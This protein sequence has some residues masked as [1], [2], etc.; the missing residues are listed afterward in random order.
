[1]LWLPLL[2]VY[3]FGIVDWWWSF[4]PLLIAFSFL[5]LCILLRSV[6]T[7]A[8]LVTIVRITGLVVVACSASADLPLAAWF[9]I[10]ALTLLDLVDGVIARRFGATEEGAILDMEADH[11]TVMLLALLVVRGGGPSWVLLVPAIRY[12]FVVVMWAV[13]RPAHEPRPVDGDN[14]RG[15]VC[16]AIVVGALLA[17]LLPGM[18]W[19]MTVLA[20][21]VA[22]LTLVIS[23]GADALFLLRARPAAKAGP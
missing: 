3:G 12:L 10:L 14:K 15:R 2:G 20:G 11:F 13:G 1:M 22:V 6:R 4:W 21:G 17:A 23:F 8:D 7:A 16:C 18:S 9:S 19:T 5:G